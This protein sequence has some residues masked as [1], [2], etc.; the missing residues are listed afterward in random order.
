M[1]QVFL[2]GF[3]DRTYLFQFSSLH[4]FSL[5]RC[6]ALAYIHT[7]VYNIGR[8]ITCMITYLLF[9]VLAACF[10]VKT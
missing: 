2:V 3:M 4:K 5:L 1:S 8:F 9:L 10:Y 6:N 7:D